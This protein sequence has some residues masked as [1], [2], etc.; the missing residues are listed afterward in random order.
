MK[1][2][3]LV[4]SNFVPANQHVTTKS[5]AINSNKHY[6]WRWRFNFLFDN[7]PHMLSALSSCRNISLHSTE[8]QKPNPTSPNLISQKIYSCVENQFGSQ[9]DFWIILVQWY[10]HVIIS[11]KRNYNCNSLT[12][13]KNNKFSRYYNTLYTFLHSV[14]TYQMMHSYTKCPCS[15]YKIHL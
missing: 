3:L 4:N 13:S 2:R 15:Y 11:F 9:S 8:S 7:A 5:G 10:K 6:F 12:W 14:F 1:F